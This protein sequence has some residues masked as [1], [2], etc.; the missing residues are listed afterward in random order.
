MAVASPRRLSLV[1][2]FGQHRIGGVLVRDDQVAKHTCRGTGLS[3]VE[4]SE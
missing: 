3:T 1:A 2:A 4:R